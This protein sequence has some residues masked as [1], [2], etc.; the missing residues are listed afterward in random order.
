MN[1]ALRLKLLGEGVFARND[2]RKNNY[3]LLSHEKNL[4][5]LIDLSLG[6]SDLLPP[7]D[8]ILEIQKAYDCPENSSYCLESGTKPFC[9]AVA[10][11]CKKRFGISVN[12]NSEVLLLIG[13]QEGTAHLPIAI[14]NPRQ[15][16]LI[17]DPCYPSHRGGLILADAQIEKLILKAENGW[18]PNFNQLSISQLEELRIMILGYPHNPTAQVGRQEYLDEAINL[19]KR[20][21]IVVAHDNPYVDLAIEGDAPCLLR[22][23]GWREYGIEFFSFSKAWN[24]GGFRL[25]FAIGAEP[26]IKALKKVKSVIDF[27][28]SLAIQKGGIKALN[29]LYDW[30]K[31]VLETY[32]DRRDKTVNAFHQI[33]WDVPTPSMA[34]YIWMPLPEWAIKKGWDEEMMASQIL[35]STGVALTPGSGFGSGG[36]NWLRLALVRPI[37]ELEKATQKIGD[38]INEQN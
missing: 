10:A 30:P 22:C 6:S 34:M 13:S 9:E 36:K 33:G 38:W 37:S 28:Q 14:L 7:P 4:S 11:W 32:R 24:M 8:V 17:L 18:E 29:D 1:H 26:I 2:H 35:N 25:A 20:Y 15:S 21:Q 27:N 12:P 16:G 3:R 31:K 23:D 5:P 19:G